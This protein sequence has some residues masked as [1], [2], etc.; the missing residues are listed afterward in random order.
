MPDFR[1]QQ[2]FPIAEVL[3]AAQ[4][5]ARLQLQAQTQGQQSLVE[6]LKSIGEVGQSLFDTRKRV[7]QSLALGKQF[8]IPDDL[9]RTMAPEQILK[10]GAIKKSNIDMGSLLQALHGTT[11]F[12]NSA[13]SAVPASTPLMPNGASGGAMLT[14]DV[15]ATPVPDPSVPPGLP[16]PTTGQAPV[17]MSAPPSAP[18]TPK[19]S[20]TM[21]PATFS[22]LLKLHNMTAPQTVMSNEDALT[23][24]SVPH[25]TKIIH[26][27]SGGKPE[28]VTYMGNTPDGKPLLLSKDG[29]ISIGKVPGDGPVLPKSSTQ[30]TAATRTTSE[31]ARTIIPHIDTMRDLV[32]QADAKGFIGP[33]AG[34][35]YSNFLTGKVGTTGNAEADRLLGRLRATDSLLKTGAM[36]VHFGSRGGTQMYDHFSDMLNS[37]KQS[38][39]VL[40]GALDGIQDFMQGY[41][42]PGNPSSPAPTPE[43]SSH[44]PGW[45]SENEQRL[46]MLLEKQ[47]NGSLRS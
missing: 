16:P 41:A 9:S 2:N 32:N 21:N 38:K 27:E 35:I 24:G 17:P 34:R 45:T 37:G 33:A 13:G 43:P 18:A 7:A 29:T 22:A 31:F 46:Q 6:G 42:N 1:M 5:N 10:V 11:P 3:N 25:G 28:S 47:K 23:A 40:N 20:K 8:D 26:T 44:A 19:S 12:P 30:P 14:S 39:A 36:K 4:Q 15:T